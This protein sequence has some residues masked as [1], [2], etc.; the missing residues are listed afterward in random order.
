MK[1]SILSALSFLMRAKGVVAIG[2]V[3]FRAKQHPI[4]LQPFDS[5]MMGYVLRYE[6]DARRRNI[7][8]IYRT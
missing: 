8:A 5:G 6:N 4:A 2:K 3:F 7:S 1:Q